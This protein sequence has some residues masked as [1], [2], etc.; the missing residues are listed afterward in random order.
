MRLVHELYY[1]KKPD[2]YWQ[3]ILWLN[4]TEINLNQMGP[5]IGRDLARTTTVTAHW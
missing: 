2:K 5:V 1:E 4:E 3:Y